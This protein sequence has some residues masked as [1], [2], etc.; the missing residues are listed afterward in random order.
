MFLELFRNSKYIWKKLNTSLKDFRYR[1]S[2]IIQSLEYFL[3]VTALFN[4]VH[5]FLLSMSRNV[6]EFISKFQIVFGK[7]AIF[8]V[9]RYGWEKI[10]I[11]IQ[12][13]EGMRPFSM[14]SALKAFVSSKKR[15]PL[16]DRLLKD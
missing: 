3:V 10:S 12:K 9:W 11:H 5:R 2:F 13:P 8:R 7:H 4:L 15:I 16:F 1:Y 6:L 14:E